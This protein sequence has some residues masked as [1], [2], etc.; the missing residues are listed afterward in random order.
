MVTISGSSGSLRRASELDELHA[1]HPQLVYLAA[2]GGA[3]S[4][5][6]VDDAVLA[7]DPTMTGPLFPISSSGT[8]VVDFVT[9]TVARP[10]ARWTEPHSTS[11]PG[12]AFRTMDVRQTCMAIP[13]L[14][15]PPFGP[16]VSVFHTPGASS[17]G[18]P[19]TG[20]MPLTGGFDVDGNGG[21]TQR[22]TEGT[23]VRISPVL[24]AQPDLQTYLAIQ[25]YILPDEQPSPCIVPFP[26]PQ[27]P[28]TPLD[29]LRT[30]RLIGQFQH[31]AETTQQQE[32]LS[33]LLMQRQSPSSQQDYSQD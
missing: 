6:P 3:T 8:P 31:L 16:M 19:L 30:E 28:D 24:S 15:P 23:P 32:L 13:P 14:W 26:S 18:T 11:Q 12:N 5:V 25:S 1:G 10:R 2:T 22:H 27:T 9:R 33:Q 17:G 29:Y 21:S 20:G 7:L 4:S